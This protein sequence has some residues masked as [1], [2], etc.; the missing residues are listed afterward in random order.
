MSTQHHSARIRVCYFGVCFFT[1]RS[2]LLFWRRLWGLA[3]GA[4]ATMSTCLGV[5]PSVNA[6]MLLGGMGPVKVDLSEP[7]KV[8]AGL[9][10]S[11]RAWL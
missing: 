4:T 6:A 5:M 3:C 11:T 7:G 2:H 8:F 9:S 10:H 1:W